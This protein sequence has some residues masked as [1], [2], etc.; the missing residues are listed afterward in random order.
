M[1][2]VVLNAAPFNLIW[3]SSVIAK[4]KTVNVVGSSPYSF[5][6]NGAVLL[7]GPSPPLN[8]Q[9]V[10]EQTTSFTIGLKWT[11]GD[12]NGGSPVLDYAVWSD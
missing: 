4:I 3:G 7:N 2:N 10:R 11:E 8:F 9:E 12:D 5:L 6:G 1:P